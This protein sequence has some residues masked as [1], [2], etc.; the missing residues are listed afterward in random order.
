MSNNKWTQQSAFIYTYVCATIIEEDVMNLRG[1][2][3]E[4]RGNWRWERER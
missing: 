2:Q 1:N 3:E 4:D